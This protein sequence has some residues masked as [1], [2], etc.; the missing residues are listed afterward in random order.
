MD[1]K[2]KQ[3]PSPAEMLV[4]YQSALAVLKMQNRMGQLVPTHQIKKL[5]KEIARLLTRKK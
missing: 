1:K 5:K 4:K 2:K 3:E